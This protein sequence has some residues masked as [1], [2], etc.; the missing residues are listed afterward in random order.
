MRKEIKARI[1][2]FDALDISESNAGILHNISALPEFIAT[3][4]IFTYLSIG[5]EPDTRKLIELCLSMGKTVAVPY[6]YNAGEMHFALLDRP[7]EAL[8]T[9]VFGIPVPA[10]DAVE[11]V[12]KEGDLLVVPALCCDEYGYRLGRGGGYY[13]RYLTE[14]AFF[15]VGLCR[16]ALLVDKVPLDVWDKRVSCVITDKRIARPK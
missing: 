8:E 13:D 1:A 12:P 10:D 6:K 11:L 16:E 5:R 14:H 3:R 9:G 7:A 2:Q 4:R 15:S